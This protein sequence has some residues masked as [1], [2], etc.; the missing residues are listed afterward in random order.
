MAHWRTHLHGLARRTRLI[1]ALATCVAFLQFA[2]TDVFA[3][4]Y[5]I[6]DSEVLSTNAATY[7]LEFRYYDP[8]PPP[9]DEPAVIAIPNTPTP[10]YFVTATGG[11]GIR[12][13]SIFCDF[14]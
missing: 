12:N 14:S 13:H 1:P 7:R 8:N 5:H 11:P 10:N 2:A 3:G 6:E 4:H 9:G